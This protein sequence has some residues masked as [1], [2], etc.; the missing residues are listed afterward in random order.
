MHGNIHGVE[1]VG[2]YDDG[3]RS[4]RGGTEMRFARGAELDDDPSPGNHQ[5]DPQSSHDSPENPSS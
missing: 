3:T 1:H 2:R 4:L 5:D